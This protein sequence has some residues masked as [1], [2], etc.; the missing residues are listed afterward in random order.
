MANPER[1]EVD[2]EVDGDAVPAG[3]GHGRP[4][5]DPA[6]REHA[7]EA[8]DAAPGGTT[9]RPPGTSE[10]LGVLIWGAMPAPPSGDRRRLGVDQIL[11]DAVAACTVQPL[12]S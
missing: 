2:L 8:R 4:A 12:S 3:A 9:A 6:R 1:G 5:R 11:D 10:Y 7:A